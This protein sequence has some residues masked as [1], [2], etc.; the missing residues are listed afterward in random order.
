M[1]RKFVIADPATCIGCKTCMAACFHRHDVPND[2][3]VPRLTLVTTRTIS[4]PLPSTWWMTG[5]SVYPNSGPTS[6][7]KG[8]PISC[9]QSIVSPLLSAS[10]RAMAGS[11]GPYHS[12]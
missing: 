5:S 3:A 1:G 8:T 6:F 11:F 4:A 12:G 10:T 9:S 7:R 2:V